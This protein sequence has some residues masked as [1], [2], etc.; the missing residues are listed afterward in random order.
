[1]EQ[2]KSEQNLKVGIIIPTMNRSGFIIRQLRYYATVKCPHTIYIGDSSN[3]EHSDKIKNAVNGFNNQIKIVYKNIPSLNDREAICY[4]LSLVKE[5][6]A[7]FSGDDDYQIP[8]SL[9]K[10]AQFLENNPDYAT[11]SGY[12]VSFRLEKHGVHGEL[13][14]LADYPRPHMEANT[15][16]ERIIEYFEKSYVPL[17]SVNRTRQMLKNFE[18]MGEVKDKSFGSEIIPCALSIIAGKSMTLD[19]LG[20]VRQIHNNHYELPNIFDWIT[21]QEW[22][23]S[24]DFFEKILSE[25]ISK[26]DNISIENAVKITKQAFWAYLNKYLTKDYQDKYAR[27][28][29]KTKSFLNK[30][31]L[32]LTKIFPFLKT[33]Y[34]TWIKKPAEGRM[35]L[36]YKVLQKSS[37]YYNDFQ[38]VMDSFT[39][40]LT[41]FDTF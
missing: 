21:S 30:L 16:H 19:C 29:L 20:F 17:F 38:P 41:P 3:Q 11:A 14:R 37:P 7:C 8:G 23:S 34:R 24:Y 4:L 12:A 33:L 39:G 32:I 25:N 15:A 26:K 31:R 10:C 36:H 1:M 6:Y 5:S 2:Y 13:D 28:K 18:K 35:D 40:S 9:T 22:H 27:K